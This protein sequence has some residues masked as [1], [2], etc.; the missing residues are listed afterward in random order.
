MGYKNLFE[1]LYDDFFG[2]EKLKKENEK[3]AEELNLSAN[4]PAIEVKEE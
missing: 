3:L 2:I 4:F 1:S